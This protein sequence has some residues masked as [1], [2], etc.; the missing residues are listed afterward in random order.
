MFNNTLCHILKIDFDASNET[1]IN[2]VTFQ[3]RFKVFGRYYICCKNKE[4]Q[5]K[6]RTMGKHIKFGLL[7][8]SL[9]L[10]QYYCTM[11]VKLTGI[12][13][14]LAPAEKPE[15]PK[16]QELNQESIYIPTG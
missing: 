14:S 3:L 12:S 11:L 9:I 5:K 15:K 7:Y 13:R 16:L 2:T 6:M 1:K 8:S 10:R 4:W